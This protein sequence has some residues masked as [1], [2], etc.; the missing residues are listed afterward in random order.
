LFNIEM[1][2]SQLRLQKAANPNNVAYAV[3]ETNGQLSVV[4]KS[5]AQPVAPSDLHIPITKTLM[6]VVLINDG[7]VMHENLEG[8][9]WNLKKLHDEL[10]RKGIRRLELQDVLNDEMDHQLFYNEQ[11]IRITDPAIRQFFM[12]LRDDKTNNVTLLH[13][14]INKMMQQGNV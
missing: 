8:I 7:H 13:S 3:I 6:P 5:S 1:L 2:L 14:E 11:F 9:G 12:L 10:E 4:K